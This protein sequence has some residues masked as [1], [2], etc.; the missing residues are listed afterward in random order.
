MHEET[1]AHWQLWL[2]AAGLAVQEMPHGPRYWNATLAIDAAKIGHGIAL[3]LDLLVE[4]ELRNGELVELLDTA[5][6]LHSY[7][8]STRADRWDE[9]VIA[10]FRAWLLA[11]FNQRPQGESG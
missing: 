6:Y 11:Q 7:L 3:A 5:V 8:F 10:R 2:S 4:H 9:P 1:H